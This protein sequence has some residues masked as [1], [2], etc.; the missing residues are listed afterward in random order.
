MGDLPGLPLDSG[1]G[2]LIG[3]GRAP[4]RAL[5]C[6]GWLD[7]TARLTFESVQDARVKQPAIDLNAATH[8]A[9]GWNTVCHV[10]HV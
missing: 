8:G 3:W 9:G 1:L 7:R 5:P 4:E 2:C 6:G 10:I